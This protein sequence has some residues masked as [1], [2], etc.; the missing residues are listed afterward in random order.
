A[1]PARDTPVP[2]TPLFRSDTAGVSV[3]TF[4]NVASTTTIGSDLNL[5]Y[6]H[7]PLMLGG[8]GSAYHYKSDAS[9]LAGNLSTSTFGWSLTGCRSEEHTS[10]LQPHLTLVC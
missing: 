6:R 7:G 4:A 1:P 5:N 3:S 10:E 9:N 8:G 2:Y